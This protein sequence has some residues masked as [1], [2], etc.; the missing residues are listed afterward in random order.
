MEETSNTT[1]DNCQSFAQKDPSRKRRK[2]ST[3]STPNP[4]NDKNEVSTAA[5]RKQ[6]NEDSCPIYKLSNDELKL[7]FGYIGDK[8]YRFVAGTSYRFHQ[9]YLDTFGGEALTS[10]VNAVASVSCA[11]MCLH[12]EEPDCDHR[13]VSLFRA[14]VSD[15]KLDVLKWGEKSGHE[16]DEMLDEDKIADTA[17]N[18]HLEVVTYLRKLGISWD[19]YTCSSASENGHLELLKWARANKCPWNVWTCRQAAKNGHLE[20]LTWWR[21]NLCLWDEQICKSVALN[22]HLEL[23]KWARAN[24]YPWDEWT[25]VYAARNGHLD[26]LKWC[27]ENRCPWNAVT[28]SA[29]AE[30]GHL[31]L[32]KWAR[33]NQCPWNKYTCMQAAK[34]GHL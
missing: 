22:G 29:A 4:P 19:K 16:L 23:L 26:L 32:L 21:A 11:A 17:L 15:G 20:V 27:R 13:A 30:N 3:I 8:Q 9:V 18:G 5:I 33:A 28:F 25:C 2:T 6:K 14:A 31:E 24:Q 34:N 7:V 10:I 1:S 12:S